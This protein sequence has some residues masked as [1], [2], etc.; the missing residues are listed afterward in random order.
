MFYG[1][2]S[3][4]WWIKDEFDTEAHKD[5]ARFEGW[6]DILFD[7]RV[8]QLYDEHDGTTMF[9]PFEFVQFI[10]REMTEYEKSIL[11]KAKYQKKKEKD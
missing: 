10:E 6:I 7:Y 1:T 9:I 5:T 3:I 8:V 2:V 4:S 11:E